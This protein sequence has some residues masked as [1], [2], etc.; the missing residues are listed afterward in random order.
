MSRAWGLPLAE[1]LDKPNATKPQVRVPHSQRRE[2]VRGAFR[3]KRV[4][5]TGWEV[6]LIDDVK[7][8]GGDD[9]GMREGIEGERGL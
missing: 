2:N 3:T 8:T 6:W 7:T 5:L 1:L 4:D 9:D